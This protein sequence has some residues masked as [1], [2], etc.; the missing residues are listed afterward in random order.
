MLTRRTIGLFG[1]RRFFGVNLD[2]DLYA[3]LGV[4]KNSS[5]Q[6]IKTAYT[7]L[8]KQHHPDVKK[9]DDTLFKEINMAY[10]ILSN[11]QKKADYDQYAEQKSKMRDFQ[12]REGN[13][14]S[15][16]SSSSIAFV[17]LWRSVCRQPKVPA[18]L[19]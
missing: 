16:V 8:V 13:T 4:K 9:G 3:V 1:G 2:K 17:S 7:K 5:K 14:Y 11:D 10:S 12:G 18:R 19:H 15:G 6:E